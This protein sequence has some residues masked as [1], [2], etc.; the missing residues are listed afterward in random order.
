M[1]VYFVHYDMSLDPAHA[2]DF[3]APT[4]FHHIPAVGVR[5][6]MPVRKPPTGGFCLI[7]GGTHTLHVLFIAVNHNNYLHCEW[8]ALRFSQTIMKIMVSDYHQTFKQDN[9]KLI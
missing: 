6:F 8:M 3:I 2:R 1:R 4:F 5:L 7:Q 9:T